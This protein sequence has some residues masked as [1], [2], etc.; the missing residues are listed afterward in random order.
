LTLFIIKINRNAILKYLKNTQIA[1]RKKLA[2]NEIYL[3]E[4]LATNLLQA[5]LVRR[6][7]QS[8]RQS[9]NNALRS[10][11]QIEHRIAMLTNNKTTWL[12]DHVAKQ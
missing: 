8:H 5:M 6:A 9:S 1:I 12:N 11:T 3:Y 7:E 4:V 2:G 10:H